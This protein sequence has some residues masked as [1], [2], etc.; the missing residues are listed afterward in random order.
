MWL[1]QSLL[2]VHYVV[3]SSLKYQGTRDARATRRHLGRTNPPIAFCYLIV[4]NIIILL[5]YI[6]A[7]ILKLNYKI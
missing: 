2:V 1:L 7:L 3:W 4:V 5:Y 6:V